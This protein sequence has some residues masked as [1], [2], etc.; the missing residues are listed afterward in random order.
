MAKP[1]ALEHPPTRLALI[2][3]LATQAAKQTE[4][5]EKYGVT[6]QAVS[7]FAERHRLRIDEVRRD[8]NNEFAGIAYAKLANRVEMLDGLVEYGMTLLDDPDRQA[9][10][11][12]G[13]A[14]ILGQVRA[15]A[16]EIAEQLGQLPAR[17]LKMEGGTTVRYEIVGVEPDAY[18]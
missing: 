11:S 14:E 3:E 9:K 16:H 10:L 18:S 2:R 4:L 7:A 5:A 15:A 1:G 17:G 13:T 8:V 12:V 6:P